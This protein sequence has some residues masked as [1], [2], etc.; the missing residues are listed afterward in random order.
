MLLMP[1]LCWLLHVP[2]MQVRLHLLLHAGL[3]PSWLCL[4]LRRLPKT[5][6]CWGT[7]RGTAL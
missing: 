5:A 6:L 7:D 3:L 1:T 2:P 4:Q